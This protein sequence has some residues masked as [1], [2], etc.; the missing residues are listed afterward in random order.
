MRAVLMAVS[1]SNGSEVSRQRRAT[2]TA[3]LMAPFN[4]SVELVRRQRMELIEKAQARVQV[5]AFL[6]ATGWGIWLS[7][8]VW[9]VCVQR[10]LE[11]L[12]SIFPTWVK[13]GGVPTLLS[14]PLSL[15]PRPWVAIT[16]WRVESIQLFDHVFFFFYTVILTATLADTV[17]LIE[18][19]PGL[20]D[21]LDRTLV[22]SRI[23]H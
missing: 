14:S 17:T 3:W 7:V 18:G 4:V 1:Q 20:R 16:S 23:F 11:V 6:P 9:G 10:N 19:Y 13:V 8:C 15:L 21:S 2:R 22:F 12:A 5:C